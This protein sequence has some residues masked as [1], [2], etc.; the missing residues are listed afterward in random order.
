MQ[1]PT[2]TPQGG[3]YALWMPRAGISG[4]AT[5][6]R[7]WVESINTAKQ[8]ALVRYDPGLGMRSRVF[9]AHLADID[10]T[11]EWRKL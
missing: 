5:S 7:V 10:F 11:R 6:G 8:T 1:K 3:M 9:C 2:V 4:S